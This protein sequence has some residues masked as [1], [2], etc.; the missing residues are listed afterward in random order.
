[1]QAKAL[2]GCLLGCLLATGAEPPQ[3]GS[4]QVVELEHWP[5]FRADVVERVTVA[6]NYRHLSGPTVVVF[7]GTPLM[8][9]ASGRARV[10]GQGGYLQIEAEFRELKSPIQF[11]AEYLTYVLWAITPEGRA[12][13]LGEVLVQ[14]GRSRLKV[15]TELQVF[16]MIV[17][18]EPYFAVRQPSDL[19]VLENDVG[20]NPRSPFELVDARFELLQRGQYRRLAN[21]LQLTLD[22][23]VPLQLYEARNA[24][25]IARS[26]GA[27][28][29]AKDV[30]LKAEQSLRQAEAY[31]ARKADRAT[32]IMLARE[33]VQRAEDA[34]E[35]AVRQQELER[36]ARER[37]EAMRREAEARAR[38]EEEARKRAEAE[39][40]R[41]VKE[42]AERQAREAAAR[43]ATE[44]QRLEQELAQLRAR[45]E[46]ATD[47]A[48]RLREL[49]RER[50]A[51]FGEER[52]R[53]EL[54]RARREAE[55]AERT[56]LA[57]RAAK[58]ERRM[59]LL[60]RLAE[61]W[62]VRDVGA[63]LLVELPASLFAGQTAQLTAPAR[64]KLAALAGLLS[65]QPG[66]YFSLQAVAGS[67]S[68]GDALLRE[69]SEAVREFLTRW[70]A[71]PAP[72]GEV[73]ALTT[74]QLMAG[75]SP[76]TEAEQT[77]F[78]L[79]HG[80]PISGS[81]PSAGESEQP[82]SPSGPSPSSALQQKDTG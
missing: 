61:A 30:L 32:V 59:R 79:I 16:G 70:G 2:I 54:E 19:V 77:L 38:A 44:R 39:R 24:V 41:S 36:L 11:G 82:V 71:V 17:T 35:L 37:Q 13:N 64:E 74:D 9:M 29:Y 68:S 22:P 76:G 20:P 5:V 65:A 3:A 8:P 4:P 67:S 48:G 45:L 80:E 72:A 69:R 50:T 25:Q 81:T 52:A 60:A 73:V 14:D 27:A 7:R 23:N 21:P 75:L 18:A 33:A 6:I 31:W 28:E 10:S 1:M 51:S 49:L 15:T 63:G 62:R 66:V 78:V 53:W 56:R 58:A 42:E 47:E 46:Q 34:R 12:A 26:S 40:L 43:E 55:M 57:E